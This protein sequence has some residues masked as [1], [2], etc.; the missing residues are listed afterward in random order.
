MLRLATIFT[1]SSAA[2]LTSGSAR[3]TFAGVMVAHWVIVVHNA[4]ALLVQAGKHVGHVVREEALVVEHGGQHLCH[5]AG[6]H[7]LVVLVPVHLHPRAQHLSH[8]EH[9]TPAA[10]AA[11]DRPFRELERLLLVAGV[12]AVARAESGV[13][14]H[15]YEVVAGDGYHRAAIVG[16]W[17]E[18]ALVRPGGGHLPTARLHRL[19]R[20]LA[21]EVGNRQCKAWADIWRWG[22]ETDSVRHGLTSGGGD[23]KQTV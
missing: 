11:E 10:R 14:G 18:V 22:R 8:G 21:V 15:H 9:V 16:V 13:G 5:G 20:H 3:V 12:D 7:G 17:V 23:G 2:A 6:G 4:A 19:Q 1:S